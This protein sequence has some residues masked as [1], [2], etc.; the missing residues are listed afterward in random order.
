MNRIFIDSNIWVY[1]FAEDGSKSRAATDFISEC[2]KSKRI[3][4]SYQVINEVCC[5]LKKKKYSETEIRR[6]ASDM[7]SLCEICSCSKQI[8]VMASGLRE[9]FSLSYWDSLIISS[10]MISGCGIL[11]S[12]DMQDGLKIDSMKIVNIFA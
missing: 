9:E 10:A 3:V 12:E 11:A 8:I 2:A 4:T 6:I 5:V 7:I 1:L